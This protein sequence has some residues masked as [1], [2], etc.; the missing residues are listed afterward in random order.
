MEMEKDTSDNFSM[1][2]GFITVIIKIMKLVSPILMREG[3]REVGRGRA[4]LMVLPPG[5]A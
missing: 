3:Y 4:V 1:Q 5:S 2:E